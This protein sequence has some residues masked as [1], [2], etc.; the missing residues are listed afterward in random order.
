M[1]VQLGH[2]ISYLK[3]TKV[4]WVSVSTTRSNTRSVPKAENK[5]RNG[6]QINS[7]APTNSIFSNTAQKFTSNE[8]EQINN[9][10][11]RSRILENFRPQTKFQELKEKTALL[12]S[13]SS[14][15]FGEETEASLTPVADEEKMERVDSVISVVTDDPMD[16]L[17]GEEHDQ[18]KPES[19]D[20]DDKSLSV[21][22]IDEDFARNEVPNQVWVYCHDTRGSGLGD[23]FC[24]YNA[25]I[26]GDF[27]SVA[28]SKGRTRLLKALQACTDEEWKSSKIDTQSC[29]SQDLYCT[30]LFSDF[31]LKNP[32]LKKRNKR[33]LDL[34]IFN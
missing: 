1:S 7:D 12:K 27:A 33:V 19:E 17:Y 10:Y 3:N 13:N 24:Q 4:P 21:S 26:S 9:A 8:I 5:P 23:K 25:D 14:T 30:N 29:L 6:A 16:L 15:T 18:H 31:L 2:G 32:N 28:S 34:S 20:E 22:S 11:E